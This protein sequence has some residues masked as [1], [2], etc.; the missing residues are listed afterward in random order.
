MPIGGRAALWTGDART[1]R[2]L[3]E[4]PAMR[5]F[6]GPALA[7]DLALMSAGIAALEGRRAEAF[8][9]FMDALRSFEDLGLRFDGAAGAVDMAVLLPG[10]ES[11][12]AAAAEAISAAR[13][14]LEQLNAR[15]YLDHL[16]GPGQQAAGSRI[17]GG[18]A[19]PPADVTSG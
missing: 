18:V 2:R 15:P 19:A 5:A 16:A 17:A 9:G 11:E 7:A 13:A 10:I 4:K 8:A 14:T 6:S 3:I 1:A 12:S